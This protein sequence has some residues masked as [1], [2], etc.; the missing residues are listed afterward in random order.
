MK[1]ISAHQSQ[2]LP[3]LPYFRKVALSDTFVWMDSVQFQRRGLQNRTQVW[4]EKGMKWLT[5]PVKKGLYEDRIDEKVFA[6]DG[7]LESNLKHLYSIY[8]KAPYFEPTYAFL[9]EVTEQAQSLD[10]L[11]DANRLF[12]DRL[13][14]LLEI[15]TEVISLSSLDISSNKNQLILD[16]CL[17]TNADVYLS[18]L[19]A[20]D[21]LKDETFQEQG[22]Q[23]DYFASSPPQ[24]PT[25]KPPFIGGLSIIDFLMNCHLD[26]V[27]EQVHCER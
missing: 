24:Y 3:W 17:K 2:Y 7:L 6:E 1:I 19:G 18:G 11:N 22:I 10:Y 20:K 26:D 12:F 21:Y 5:L 15:K 25:F 23:I 4:S 8:S 9:E 14:Q 27:K 13:S 16:I